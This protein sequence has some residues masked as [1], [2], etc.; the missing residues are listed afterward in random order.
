MLSSAMLYKRQLRTIV[1]AIGLSF[2]LANQGIAATGANFDPIALYGPEIYFDVLRKGKPSGLH[3]VKF[4]R[5]KDGFI[6]RSNFELSVKFLFVTAY[7][8][9]YRSESLWIGGILQHL[10][11]EVEDNG[12]PFV[13]SA[14][15]QGNSVVVDHDNQKYEVSAPL[16]P[17]NHW[18][19]EVLS[20][21]RV[22]NTLTGRVNRVTIKP[23]SREIVTTEY[24]DITANRYAYTGDLDT[25][26]W[27][28]DMG[29]WVKMRFAARDGSTVEYVCRRCQGNSIEEKQ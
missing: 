4:E 29:R 14:S 27:Y 25:E 18:N 19:A 15:K 11:A 5:T 20:Q 10:T 12:S 9:V 21:R 1:F 8:F 3:T 28:D 23:L 17:T 22:L 13:I 16:Y 26:V 24:G 2:T 6:V 7:R